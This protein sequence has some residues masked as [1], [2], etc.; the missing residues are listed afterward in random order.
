[1]ERKITSND[2]IFKRV[3]DEIIIDAG[4]A[5]SKTR[6]TFTIE[7]WTRIVEALTKGE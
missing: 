6:F 7:E 2:M 3:D 1:M 4:Y 5:G